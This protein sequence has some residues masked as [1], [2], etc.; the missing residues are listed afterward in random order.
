MSGLHH[1]L[2][3]E[4]QPPHKHV[5]EVAPGVLRIQLPMNMPGLGHV[6]CYAIEDRNGVALVDPGTPDLRSWKVLKAR[7]DEA[8]L[9]LKR[10]HTVVVTHSHPDHYG[11][12]QRIRE[13]SGAELVT[14]ENFKTYWDPHEED[15]FIREVAVPQD[16]DAQMGAIEQALLKITGRERNSPWD[17]PLPWGGAPPDGQL[18]ERLRWRIKPLL[19]T[20]L[21]QPPKPSKR[22]IDGQILMLGDREWVSVHTPGHT[23]DHLCL[24][25]PTHGI[26]ISGDHL[27]PTITPH[28]SG[29]TTQA[30][31]LWDFLD[32]LER[33]YTFDDVKVVLPAHG[34]EFHDLAGRSKEII[35]HHGRILMPGFVDAHVHYPQLEMIASYGEQLLQ[36]LERYTFP[37]ERR[38]GDPA[39][40]AAIAEAFLDELL[41]HGTTTAVVLGSVH[42][43]SADAIFEAAARRGL[44]LV[45]GQVMMD[46]HAPA[47]LCD[48]PQS[49]YDDATALIEAWHERP[50]TRLSYAVTPRFAATSS[51]AQLEVAARLRRE[52]PGVFMHTHWAENLDEVEWVRQLYPASASYLGVY[53]DFGLLGPR[54]VLAHGVHVAPGDL[55]RLA[56]TGSTVAL[57]PSSNLFLGSGLFDLAA[58]QRAGVSIALGTDVGAGTSLSMLRTLADAYKVTQ[59]RRAVAGQPGAR[60]LSVDDAFHAITRGGARALGLHAHIGSFEPGK[61]ADFV[62]LDPAAT[63]LLALRT[64]RAESLDE[65]LFALMMLGDD[66]AVEA[67]YVQGQRWSPRLPA[68]EGAG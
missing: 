56:E 45:A 51:P 65:R 39:H 2:R 9:P 22:V 68:R 58:L 12:A 10:V 24:L 11:A 48:T 34:L 54:A 30:R 8:G 47:D 49:A 63:P 33:M 20:K 6:N 32:S 13:V 55:E 43:A 50:G 4:R 41:R 26:F 7:L 1:S 25:E 42:R 16:Y 46:R 64:A 36:W 40:A 37:T 31:P 59:L 18:K 19:L 38:F 53:D 66:R 15:D 44:R 67:T 61:E 28:I 52:H 60:P 3:Q 57:C 5:A 29:L 14:H 35:E 23:A 27:L 62:V 21:W 17:R